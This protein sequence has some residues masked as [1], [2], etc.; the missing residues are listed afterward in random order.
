M[1][2]VE[3]PT[4]LVGIGVDCRHALGASQA[5]GFK[6]EGLVSSLNS[7]SFNTYNLTTRDNLI[8]RL[9]Y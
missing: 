2:L 4:G 3:S 1:L 7:P 6:G 8:I 9:Y 5:F